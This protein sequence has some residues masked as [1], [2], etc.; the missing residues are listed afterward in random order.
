MF[1]NK[2]KHLFLQIV[3]RKMVKAQGV[4]TVKFM[5]MIETQFCVKPLFA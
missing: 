5:H 4:L 2:M 1:L 3:Y